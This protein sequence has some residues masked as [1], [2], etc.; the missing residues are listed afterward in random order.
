MEQ[1]KVCPDCMS[2]IPVAAKKCAHCG[3]D[4]RGVLY[5]RL[6]GSVTFIVAVLAVL[7]I[8]GLF[9]AVNGL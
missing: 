4:Q 1:V 7:F 6:P 3:K 9:A 5:T 2:Q 8:V